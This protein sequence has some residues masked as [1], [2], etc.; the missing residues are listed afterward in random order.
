MSEFLTKNYILTVNHPPYLPDLAP[1]DSFQFGQLKLAMKGKCYDD[2]E[3]I[4]KATTD[5][6]KN[7]SVNKLKH[8]FQS[9][10]DHAKRC[11][12]SKGDYSEKIQSFIRNQFVVFF[13]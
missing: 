12:E 3:A 5:I 1:S 9:F 6:L 7:I 11:I 4:Q 13:I 8:S 2:I 10:L